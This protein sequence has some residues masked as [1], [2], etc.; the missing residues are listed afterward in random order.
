MAGILPC[1]LSLHL[2]ESALSPHLTKEMKRCHLLNASCVWLEHSPLQS[3]AAGVTKA[4]IHREVVTE[5]FTQREQKRSDD[6]A[7]LDAQDAV[8]YHI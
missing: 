7:L 5:C 1:S 6:V 3:R 2:A 4:Q 8:F